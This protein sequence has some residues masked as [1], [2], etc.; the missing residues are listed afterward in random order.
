MTVLILGLDGLDYNRVQDN[1]YLS[2]F[3]VQHLEQDLD[4]ANGLYTKRVWPN[5]FS[6]TT[7]GA[8]DD[9]VEEYQPNDLYLWEKY[10][11]RVLLPPIPDAGEHHNGDSLPGGFVESF[12]PEGIIERAL[13]GLKADIED[14]VANP[15]IHVVVACTR[16]PDIVAHHMPEKAEYYHGYMDEWVSD[17]EFP[18][19]HLIVS[20][21]GFGEFGEPGI[22]GHTTDAILA[23]N[24][25]EYNTMTEFCKNWHDDLDSVV[26]DAQ[27]DA[28]GYT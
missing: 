17:L 27:L 12:A 16:T 18:D 4:G 25:C 1:G 7:G 15:G 13:H 19:H 23:S 11:S 10:P 22:D 2:E 9:E 26:R 24:F 3:D 5:I 21:H 28:L 20:D 8:S 14:A 6:G